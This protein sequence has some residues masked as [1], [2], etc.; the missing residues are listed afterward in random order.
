MNLRNYTD[1]KQ[2]ANGSTIESANQAHRYGIEAYESTLFGSTDDA[3]TA[4]LNARQAYMDTV[5][6]FYQDSAVEYTIEDSMDR[7]RHGSLYDRGSA[8]AYYERPADPH[9]YPNGTYNNPRVVDLT[10]E[11]IA[12]YN[13]GHSGFYGPTKDWG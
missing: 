1:R 10:Y 7:D 8:D 13:L 11:Q 9:W 5:D 2:Q 12:E 3:S 6:S 4:T